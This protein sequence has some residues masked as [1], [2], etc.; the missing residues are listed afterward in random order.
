MPDSQ[1][2]IRAFFDHLES[3][4]IIADAEP[5]IAAAFQRLDLAL[6]AAGVSVSA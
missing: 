6:A 1:Y 5:Q 3:H 4:P 2:P